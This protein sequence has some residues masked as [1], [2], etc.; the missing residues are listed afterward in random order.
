[1]KIITIFLPTFGR[2]GVG[3][4]GCGSPSRGSWIKRETWE[5]LGDH[6]KFKK[7]VRIRK[8]CLTIGGVRIA[9]DHWVGDGMRSKFR[10]RPRARV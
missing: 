7:D 6:C 5:M 9:S 3:T 10:F 1:M 4:G 2:D 8:A